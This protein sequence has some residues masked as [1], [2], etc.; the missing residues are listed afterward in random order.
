MVACATRVA[1]GARNVPGLGSAA[2]REREGAP[3]HGDLLDTL[4]RVLALEL[5]LALALLHVAGVRLLLLPRPE[6]MPKSLG[7][8]FD[9]RRML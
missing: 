6:C 8:S 3:L 9:P 2:E 4:L 5:G 7:T 1:G